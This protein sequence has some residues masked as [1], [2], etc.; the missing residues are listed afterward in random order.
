MRIDDSSLRGAGGGQVGGPDRGRGA[1]GTKGVDGSGSRPRIDQKTAD[2]DRIQLS[3]LSQSIRVETEDTPERTQKV[4][5]LKAA[6]RSGNYQPDL[7]EVSKSVV[8]DA[9]ES[10]KGKL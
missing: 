5:E 6:V 1:E 2:G 9:L 3:S 7:A 4:S 8:E 10:T